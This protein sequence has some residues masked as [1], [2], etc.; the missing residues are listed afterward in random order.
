MSKHNDVDRRLKLLIMRYFP[1]RGR[2]S[3]LEG[4][5]G[6]SASKWKNYY[7]EKQSATTE[8]INFWC[9]KYTNDAAWLITGETPPNQEDFPFLARVPV[10]N[11]L[12]SITDRLIWVISEWASPYGDNLF[13]YLEERSG[14]TISSAEWSQVILK[15]KPPTAEMVRVVCERRGG[16]FTEWVIH[17]QCIAPMQVD[18]SDSH[19]LNQW[20]D[21][22]TAKAEAFTKAWNSDTHNSKLTNDNK[23]T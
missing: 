8:M 7:Y 19:S 2:F 11:P 4:V 9:T 10:K 23:E 21:Y 18:P 12:G 20:K 3:A 14:G 16:I 22:E 15:I 13:Q 5:S 17:G 1:D 6:I